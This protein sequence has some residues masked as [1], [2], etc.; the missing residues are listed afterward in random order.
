MTAVS[1]NSRPIESRCIVRE[2]RMSHI[3]CGPV[4]RALDNYS[5]GPGLKCCSLSPDGFRFS[6]PR[7]NSSAL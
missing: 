5:T 3:R 4:I 1:A 2:V 7:F 6:G